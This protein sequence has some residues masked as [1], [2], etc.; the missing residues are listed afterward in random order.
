MNLKESNNSKI[1]TLPIYGIKKI[2]EGLE[3]VKNDASS[4]ILTN[5]NNRIIRD[6]AFIQAGLKNE[7]SDYSSITFEHGYGQLTKAGAT[8]QAG[9]K[10]KVSIDLQ[11]ETYGSQS[12]HATSEEIKSKVDTHIYEHLKETESS[13]NYSDW[14]FWLFSSSGKNYQHYK[15]ST[16]DTVSLSDQTITNSLTNNFS[17]Q[18]QTFHVSGDFTIEGTSMIPTTVFLFIETL[19]IT[20]KD[21]S[22]TTVISSTPVAA[23]ANG[24]TSNVKTDGKLNIIPLGK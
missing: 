24:N 4:I 20:T 18:K 9:V 1:L 13:Q 14:W 16:Q 6:E 5:E 23:D 10:G 11:I 21:G 8:V 19:N 22:T 17:E 7:Q 2:Q 12:Y 15:D 3:I